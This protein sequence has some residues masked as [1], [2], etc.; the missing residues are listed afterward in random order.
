MRQ[1]RVCPTRSRERD[2]GGRSLWLPA[3]EL[4]LLPAHSRAQNTRM[5]EPTNEWRSDWSETLA[6]DHGQEFCECC[7]PP[8][9]RPCSAGRGS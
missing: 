1:T 3:T 9:G 2:F 7:V 8:E 6:R 4:A 5:S